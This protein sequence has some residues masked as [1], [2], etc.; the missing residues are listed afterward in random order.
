MEQMVRNGTRPEMGGID[1]GDAYTRFDQRFRFG[2]TTQLLTDHDACAAPFFGRNRRLQQ[3]VEPG[4]RVERDFH[5][6]D[7]EHDAGFLAQLLLTY[8]VSTQPFA[9]RALKKVQVARMI[10]DTA[11]IGVFPIHPDGPGE[12]EAGG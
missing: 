6:V 5:A 1:A 7:D 8:A 9:A 3:I 4:R 10:D 2:F 11:G 12:R